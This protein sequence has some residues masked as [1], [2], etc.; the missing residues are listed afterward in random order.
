ML[1]INIDEWVSQY[2]TVDIDIDAM[3]DNDYIDDADIMQ[4][5]IDAN[6][7]NGTKM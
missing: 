3:I 4:A 7:I 6:T 2:P 5:L 1:M